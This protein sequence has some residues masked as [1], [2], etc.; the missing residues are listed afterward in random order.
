MFIVVVGTVVFT[1]NVCYGCWYQGVI[2]PAGVWVFPTGNFWHLTCLTGNFSSNSRFIV[3]F[4]TKFPPLTKYFFL[5]QETSF[6]V[7]KF[8]PL[9]RN[10]FLW[11][12][13]SSF[14]KKFFPPKSVENL[15]YLAGNLAAPFISRRKYQKKWHPAMKSG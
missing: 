1:V 13:I 5:W 12:E 15:C 10:S 3:A 8:L 4:D 2:F 6:S 11:Q 9:T 7:N 14:E